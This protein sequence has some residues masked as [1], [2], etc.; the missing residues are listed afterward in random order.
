MGIGSQGFQ[1]YC[2]VLSIAMDHGARKQA[3][4]NAVREKLRKS[5]AALPW[6]IPATPVASEKD[7]EEN[8]A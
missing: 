4:R 7:R 3:M 8:Q 2:R 6:S 1:D 5:L